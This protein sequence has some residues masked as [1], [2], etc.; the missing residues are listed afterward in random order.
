MSCGCKSCRILAQASGLERA[1]SFLLL[2]FL[3]ANYIGFQ[4]LEFARVGWVGQDRCLRFP[5]FRR[6]VGGHGALSE[7]RSCGPLCLFLGDFQFS[8]VLFRIQ[9]FCAR[10]QLP[11][12]AKDA[13]CRTAT[14]GLVNVGI[15]TVPSLEFLLNLVPFYLKANPRR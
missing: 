9:L 5:A 1:S 3:V 14:G 7:R 10:I 12:I 8:F 11:G 15:K 13:I 4:L 2:S 6:L